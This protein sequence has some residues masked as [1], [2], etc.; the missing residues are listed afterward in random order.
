MSLR[1]LLL[2]LKRVAGWLVMVRSR[3]YV[4][5][6]E[7]RRAGC[8]LC[9]AADLQHGVEFLAVFFAMLHVAR[10]VSALILLRLLLQLQTVLPLRR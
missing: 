9:M 2:W 5:V 4:S 7:M 1:S 10:D 3:F 6:C 8:A